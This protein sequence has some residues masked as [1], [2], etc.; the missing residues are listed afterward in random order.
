MKDI[1]YTRYGTWDRI[2]YEARGYKTGTKVEQKPG[3]RVEQK[4]GTRID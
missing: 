1:T 4:A 2:A 3:A